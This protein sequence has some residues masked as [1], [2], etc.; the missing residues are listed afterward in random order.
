[1]DFVVDVW[2]LVGPPHTVTVQPIWRAHRAPPEGIAVLNAIANTLKYSVIRAVQAYR[3]LLRWRI[4]RMHGVLN[5][6][7][8]IDG[9]SKT[10]DD[11]P[12]LGDIDG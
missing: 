1:M 8:I 4:L 9:N 6:S 2:P 10:A 7:S 3:P 11:V 5:G 12:R